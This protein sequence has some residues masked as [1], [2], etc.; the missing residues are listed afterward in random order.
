[1]AE[2]EKL[3][4]LFKQITEIITH[5]RQ[6]AYQNSNAILL[7]M[8]W[9]IGHLIVEDEQQG[10]TKAVYG[11]AVLKN[12]AKQLT[13]EFGKGFDESNLRNI[14]QFYIAFPKRDAVRHEL[15]WTHYRIIS[16]LET[17]SLR[18]Q[19]VKHTLIKYF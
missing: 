16:R 18:I 5:A 13:V 10:K 1:M 15:S 17:E 2:T 19:Y 9:Q 4:I 11:K 8:Y 12:L 14:R 3:S 6:K 7:Q